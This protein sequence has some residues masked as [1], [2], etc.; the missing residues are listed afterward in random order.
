MKKVIIYYIFSLVGADFTKP[1]N[2]V[3]FE[4]HNKLEYLS[5]LSITCLVFLIFGRMAVAYL[6]RVPARVGSWFHL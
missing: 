3:T 6:C 2:L 4:M 1:S 5:V